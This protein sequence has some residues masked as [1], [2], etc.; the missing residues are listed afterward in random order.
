MKT[1]LESILVLAN[2]DAGL[3]WS[4]G[5][6]DEAARMLAGRLNDI[7]AVSVTVSEVMGGLL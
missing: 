4:E 2:A 5:G 1:A 7:A 6:A 3:A